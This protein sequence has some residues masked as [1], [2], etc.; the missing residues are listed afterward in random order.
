MKNA[1]N[2]AKNAMKNFGPAFQSTVRNF[3]NNL[4]P[5]LAQ[6]NYNARQAMLPHEPYTSP[7][8]FQAQ[9]EAYNKASLIDRAMKFGDRNSL[10]TFDTA[11]ENSSV[12]TSGMLQHFLEAPQSDPRL[13]ALRQA[14]LNKYFTQSYRDYLSQ[15]PIVE[16]NDSN[17]AGQSFGAYAKD[18]IGGNQQ[19]NNFPRYIGIHKNIIGAPLN[20]QVLLHEYIHQAPRPIFSGTFNEMQPQLQGNPFYTGIGEA[21]SGRSGVFPN[22]EE[23]YATAGELMGQSVQNDPLLGPYYRGMFNPTNTSPTIQY[24]SMPMEIGETPQ[25]YKVKDYMK[26]TAVKK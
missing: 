3:V 9:D 10:E 15:I 23:Y 7:E 2:Q 18:F 4:P 13:N 19:S 25:T 8:D 26:G 1:L 24:N 21:Y 5:A 14:I 17:N 6:A 22:P 16:M 12:Q 20:E 11:P